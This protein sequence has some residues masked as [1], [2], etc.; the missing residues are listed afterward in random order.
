MNEHVF[1]TGFMGSGKSTIGRLLAEKLNR[2]F[3]DLDDELT[4]EFGRP[5]AQVFVEEGQAFFRREETAVLRKV[6]QGQRLITA[7][8]GG[9]P[10]I[11]ANREVMNN[12]GLTVHL[13][14]SLNSCR[15]RVDSNG[16]RA[17]R[18]NW[19]DDAKAARLYCE[20]EPLYKMAKLT[21]DTD[22][23]TPDEIAAELAHRV[24]PDKTFTFA[25]EGAECP[26]T[27]SLDG[28][29]VLAKWTAGR[30]VFLLTDQRVAKHHLKRY[31]AVLDSPEVMVI[32]G[33][34]ATK[35]L[36]TIRLIYDKL[37]AH[38]FDRGDMFVALGGG[39]ITDMGAFA[40]ATYKRGMDFC[41]A[42]T[43]L[44]GCVDASV[45]GKTG[46][47][48]GPA[49]NGVGCFAA[50]KGVVLDATALQTLPKKE[51]AEGLIEAY[52]TG[53]VAA[54]DLAELV[55]REKAALLEG[56]TPLS[57]RVAY[58]SAEVKAEVVSDDF[59]ENGRRAILNLGHTYGHAVEAFHDYKISHGQAV[60][61]GLLVAVELSRLRGLLNR[62][63][64]AD[65]AKT[66]RCLARIPAAPDFEKAWELMGHDKKI[67]AGK[68]VFVLLEGVGRPKLVHDVTKEE[69]AKAAKVLEEA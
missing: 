33:G 31:T 50:P 25:M 24:A 3:V 30:R 6:A 61:A 2:G 34:E 39:V 9:A 60:A 52:K 20:R 63:V 46:V 22:N 57:G 15:T 62:A 42:S 49:K 56:D 29:R 58:R 21:V 14:A 59:R 68:P 64:A 17:C 16:G 10:I 32:R 35:N 36:N 8:G 5:I 43:S 44:L 41:L 23:R 37:L 7:V 67:K 28:P 13:A 55:R 26:V 40:A 12:T 69:L 66:A 65:I 19:S 38:R 18:P 4:R 1:L 45:G 51:T 27:V 47:N 48:L 11:A 54:P 53:L